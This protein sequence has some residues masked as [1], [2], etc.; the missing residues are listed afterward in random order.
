MKNQSLICGIGIAALV[1]M[2]LAV[3]CTSVFPG[4]APPTPTPLP[5]TVPTIVPADTPVSYCG[6]TTCH[7]SD[8]ACSMDA[9]QICTEEYRVGDKCRQYARCD[10]SSGGCTL[11][12]TSE[13]YATCK[14]CADRCQ[15]QAGANSQA[16]VTCE[17]KC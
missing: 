8:L 15:I 2:L 11:V 3:G 1:A 7:G 5:S 9:P 10:T 16:A 6:F 14:A 12:V 4:S 17:E 13:K